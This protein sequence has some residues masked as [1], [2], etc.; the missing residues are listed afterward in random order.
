MST[1]ARPH[2]WL[3]VEPYHV[4]VEE[5][6]TY[7]RDG[8]LVVRGLVERRHVEALIEHTAD[9]MYGRIELPRVP[10][11][12]PGSSL[13]EMEKRL[14]RIHMLH[15]E[16]EMWERYLLYP[17]VLDV[18]QSLIGPDVLA[19]QTMMFIKGPGADGQGYHQDT[20]YIPT[21]PDTLIGA[22]IALDT[23]DTEN[24]CLRMCTGSHI[25][26]I[27]PPTHG[28]GFGDW[29][30]ADIPTVLG[31]GGH[32][33]DDE[34][35]K[36]E[37]RPIA[38]RYADREVPCVLE[39]GDVAFFGGHVLHRSLRNKTEDRTRRSFVNHYCN[40]RSFT[41]WDGGNHKHI[42]A[43]GNTHL[44]FAQPLFG[45][46]CAALDPARKSISDGQ[47][48]PAMMMA[49]PAGTMAA[50]VPEELDHED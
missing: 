2:P 43:R 5:Y 9:L 8:F 10:P 31:V 50:Q 23:A 7:R 33:N 14:L 37:L 17:R 12:V 40:A 21:F 6:R 39:P 49:S 30:L 46:P 16:V 24:G 41:T 36:N 38:A 11:P 1:V 35:A 42:L 29:G 27:Y 25:E 18:V 13:R 4:S 3:E 32:S 20:Y 19:M 44:P 15:R 34:D 45:T 22:W 47:E 26:P 48:T 28:H